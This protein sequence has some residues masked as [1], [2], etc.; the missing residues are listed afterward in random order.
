MKR[1][2]T[3]LFCLVTSAAMAQVAGHSS[4]MVPSEVQEAILV[5][6]KAAPH[7]NMTAQQAEQLLAGTLVIEAGFRGCGACE[8]MFDA[9]KEGGVLS[10]WEKKGIRFYQIDIL[11][12]RFAPLQKLMYNFVVKAVKGD[13]NRTGVPWL[14]IFKDGKITVIQSGFDNTKRNKFVENL[15]KAT[16]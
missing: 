10:K 16:L 2:L 11:N 8:N 13:L 4:Q 15:E 7:S 6:Y 5:K 3:F 12:K 14:F 9:M 1:V